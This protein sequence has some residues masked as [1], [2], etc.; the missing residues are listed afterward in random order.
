ME[1]QT[2]PN[3]SLILIFGILSIVGCCCSGFI[4]L[5][6]GIIAIVLANKATTLYNANPE[7]YDGYHNVKTGK[8][9]AIVGVIL[10]AITTIFSI[11]FLATAGVEGYQQIIEDFTRGYQE[12]SS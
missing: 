9:L 5:I 11:W 2:L 1:K 6:F 8:T 4:G 3:S 12:G 7:L 10:C